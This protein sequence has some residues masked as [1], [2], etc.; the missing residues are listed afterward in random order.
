MI[1]DI[2]KKVKEVH[3]KL[4]EFVSEYVVASSEKQRTII[5]EWVDLYIRKVS[6]DD[7]H[8]ISYREYY[9]KRK[10]EENK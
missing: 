10:E 7:A 9:R 3:T 2:Q 5:N 1:D 4:E 6:K 8:L